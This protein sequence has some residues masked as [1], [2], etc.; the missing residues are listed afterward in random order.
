MAAFRGGVPAHTDFSVVS[1]AE[2][3]QAQKLVDLIKK[4]VNEYGL[5]HAGG[6]TLFGRH[7]IMLSLIAFDQSSEQEHQLVDGLFKDLISDAARAGYAPYRAH[8]AF[9]DDIA[10][11]YDFNDHA[12]RR[13]VDKLKAAA[14]PNGILS[15]GKQGIWGASKK[16]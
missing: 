10:D 1:T 15:V 4:R 6:F 8:P 2:G 11:V 7:A 13:F 14:D 3:A 16:I 12:H 9:M 5:D